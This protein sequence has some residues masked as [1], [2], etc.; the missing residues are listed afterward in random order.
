L[1]VPIVIDGNNLLHRLKSAERRRRTVRNQVLEAVRREAM[2]VRV[3]FDG[4]PPAGV[5]P[6]EHLGRV[7]VIYS[8][9]RSADDVIVELI[10]P[11]RPAA[12]WI[13]VTDDRGLA[14]RVRQLGAGVRPL[15]AWRGRRP[16]AHH[17]R[18]AEPRLSSREVAEWE[19]YFATGGDDD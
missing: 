16:R 19:E 8:G 3:V 6:I 18:R 10:P 4:P 15:S 17:R 5:P 1:I 12:Q 13:V 7:Q 9:A 11:G 14:G 2:D